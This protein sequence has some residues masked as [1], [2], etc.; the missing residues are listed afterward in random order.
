MAILGGHILEVYLS[1]AE[2]FRFL[3]VYTV[4]HST[5]TRKAITAYFF[6]F[7]Q[8]IFYIDDDFKTPARDLGPAN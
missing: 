2:P 5:H 3:I 7:S 6:V 4:S 1:S 8:P